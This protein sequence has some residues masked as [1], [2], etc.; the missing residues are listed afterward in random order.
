MFDQGVVDLLPEFEP[1]PE[2]VVAVDGLPGRKV[3]GESAPFDAIV[4]PIEDGIEYVSELD[5]TLF[6]DGFGR[7]QE[8]GDPMP[9]GI[10]EVTGIGHGDTD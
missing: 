1:D 2:A 7:R 9:L 5:L 6:A 4:S 3:D 8:G 10:I